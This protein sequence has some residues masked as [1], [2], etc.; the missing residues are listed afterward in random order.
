MFMTYHVDEEEEASLGVRPPMLSKQQSHERAVADEAR[1]L[2]HHHQDGNRHEREAN[3]NQPGARV[4]CRHPSVRQHTDCTSHCTDNLESDLVRR[5]VMKWVGM[6]FLGFTILMGGV[7]A[8]LWK[9][10]ALQ[11]IDTTWIVIGVA[12]LLGVGLMISVASS[13]AKENIHI[14]RK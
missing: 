4:G 2:K 1:G 9:L 10:G 14:D 13:G 3:R 6:Y 7:F 11:N 5:C 12:I 8:A